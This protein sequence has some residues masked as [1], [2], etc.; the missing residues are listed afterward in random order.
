MC[1]N[2]D[3]KMLRVVNVHIEQSVNSSTS[4]RSPSQLHRTSLFRQQKNGIAFEAGK[5]VH[6]AHISVGQTA[7]K[8]ERQTCSRNEPILIPICVDW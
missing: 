5:T 8:D 4:D 2:R 6:P 7:E 1:P 3:F